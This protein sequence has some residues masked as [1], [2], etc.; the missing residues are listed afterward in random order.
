[1]DINHG[2]GVPVKSPT[3]TGGP[4]A[5]KK[6]PRT[7]VVVQSDGRG[8]GAGHDDFTLAGEEITL[9]DGAICMNDSSCHR[10]RSGTRT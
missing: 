7:L 5:D 10:Y 4:S 9:V 6:V 3:L 8:A 2:E 1:M